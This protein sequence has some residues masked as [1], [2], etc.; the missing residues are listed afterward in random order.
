MPVEGAGKVQ[1]H[2]RQQ[3][4]HTPLPQG[5]CFASSTNLRN[6]ENLKLD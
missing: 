5:G 3:V 4:Q 6:V 2:A 1:S